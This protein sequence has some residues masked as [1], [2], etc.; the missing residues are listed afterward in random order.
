MHLI[1]HRTVYCSLKAIAPKQACKQ[2]FAKLEG[3]WLKQKLTLFDRK[4]PQLDSVL[5]KLL[6]LK[7]I[8]E[9]R[10][11]KKTFAEQL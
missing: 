5:T 9:R 10:S 6:Q 4:M 7:R 3:G 8:I 1:L 11:G 2:S